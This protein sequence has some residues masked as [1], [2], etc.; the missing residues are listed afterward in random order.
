MASF[1]D[2][3]LPIKFTYPDEWHADEEGNNRVILLSREF[4]RDPFSEK[5]V[6]KLQNDSFSSLDE[7]LDHYL[8]RYILNS[9]AVTDFDRL[10]SSQPLIGPTGRQIQAE[11]QTFEFKDRK[12]PVGT[13]KGDL[14]VAIKG[15]TVITSE[16]YAQKNAYT[17]FYNLFSTTI[18]PTIELTGPRD[19][20]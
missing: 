2:R 8:D 17:E 18:L 14:F 6:I 15:N 12:L 7:A 13:I 1:V 10:S 4:P 20:A 9:E 16:V 19:N 3:S 11:R 5:I